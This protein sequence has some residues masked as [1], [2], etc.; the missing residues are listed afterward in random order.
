MKKL[1][2]RLRIAHHD[3]D[4]TDAQQLSGVQ[5]EPI[6]TDLTEVE[7]SLRKHFDMCSDVSFRTIETPQRNAKF[8]L[9]FVNGMVDTKTL[10]DEL[11]KPL[12]FSYSP[13]SR[14][15]IYSLKEIVEKELVPVAQVKTVRTVDE[16]IEHILKSSVAVFLD[17][18]SVAL[19]VDMSAG[20]ERAIEE[21]KTE[22]NIRG[23][24]DG[25]NENLQTNTVLIRQRI[26]SPKLKVESRKVGEITNTNIVIVYIM[27][28]VNESILKEVRRRLDGI[29]IDGVL[30][31]GYIEEFIE[32]TSFSPF[33][34]VQNTERPDVVAA[35]LLEGKIAIVSDGT[36]FV[37]IVPMTFWSA[38]QAADDH[39]E[40]FLYTTAIRWIRLALL[41]ISLTFPSFYVAATT[42]HPEMVPY[43]LI[44]SIAKAREIIPFPVV[45][46]V[47]VME[48]MFE[49]LREAGV[50]LPK[51]IG[52]AVSIVGSLVIGQAAVEASILSAPVVIVVASTGIAS[53]AIPRYNFGTSIRL[54]RFGVL[55]MAGWLGFFGIA[56]ALIAILSHMV[57]LRSFGIPYMSP[58][59]PISVSNLKDTVIRAPWWNMKFRP[60]LISNNRQR[61][62]TKGRGKNEI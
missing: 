9:V 49:G 19:T 37:L 28:L 32:D 11:L 16:A 56:V 45:L 40:R 30:E 1:I 26:S 13:H 62:S 55:F 51:E 18:E 27:G 15:R 2:K 21:P 48:C 57:T 34:Q 3:V 44:L 6:Y 54:L 46:E 14:D 24:R 22:G 60:A 5:N 17:G 43:R 33:P 47:F 12:I 58:T 39:Y 53:F 20:K 25:F 50:R 59:A 41:I 10:D 42:F 7:R 52:S 23:P 4:G 29:K 8:L 31:S 36:P 35:A 61:A 38:L